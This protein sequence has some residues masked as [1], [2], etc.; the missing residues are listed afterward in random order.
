MLYGQSVEDALPQDNDVRVFSEVMDYLDYSAL[1]SRYSDMGCPAYSPK[2]M[3]KVL[4]YAY[5]KGIRSSRRIEECLHI[6][7]RFIWLA[8]GLAPDHNTIARFRKDGGADL[9]NLFKDSV[10]CLGTPPST[11][12]PA[13]G[14]AASNRPSSPHYAS[15]ARLSPRSITTSLPT[16]VPAHQPPWKRESR[17]PPD[18]AQSKIQNPKS[19]IPNPK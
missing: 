8:G 14:G 16:T 2:T 4:G 10:L 9:E 11:A 19:Q 1:E 5:S 15:W 12:A 3:V 18:P 7:V 13:P 6:D 17:D